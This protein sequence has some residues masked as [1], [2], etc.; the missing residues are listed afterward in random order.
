MP[1]SYVEVLT[2]SMRTMS[3]LGQGITFCTA[4]FR[5]GWRSGFWSTPGSAIYKTPA[6]GRSCLLIN[7]RNSLPD[8]IHEEDQ[9]CLESRLSTVAFAYLVADNAPCSRPCLTRKASLMPNPPY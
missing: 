1:L 5:R 9:K 6:A 2:N 8:W 3:L 7:L 4:T